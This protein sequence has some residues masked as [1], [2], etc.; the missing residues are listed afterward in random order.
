MATLDHR[1]WTSCHPS[2]PT[3]EVEELAR[4]LEAV[5]DAKE[6]DGELEFME[7]NLAFQ[8][9]EISGSEIHLRVWFE[10]ESRP[11]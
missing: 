8:L 2:L 11:A 5:A 4:W 7:P 10:C 9:D 6:V 1:G 3:I